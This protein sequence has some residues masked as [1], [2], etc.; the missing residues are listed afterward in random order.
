MEQSL[1]DKLLDE[2]GLW[3][4]NVPNRKINGPF[5][6]GRNMNIVR[7]VQHNRIVNFPQLFSVLHELGHI[8]FP[9]RYKGRINPLNVSD[10]TVSDEIMAWRYAKSCINKE[11]QDYLDSV[12]IASLLTYTNHT[13]YPDEWTEE[14]LRYLLND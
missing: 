11:N 10:I 12:A 5:V 9:P 2:A 8:A 7:S 1:H 13:A 4:V 6:V 3:T 14:L